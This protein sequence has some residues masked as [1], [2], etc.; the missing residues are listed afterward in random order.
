MDSTVDLRALQ[1]ASFGAE[2]VDAK[3]AALLSPNGRHAWHAA[4]AEHQLLVVRDLPLDAHEQVALAATLGEPLSRT[5]PDAPISSCRTATKKA[6]SATSD[7]PTTP[8]TRS[9]RSRST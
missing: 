7:S 3:L 8:T 6:S 1:G 2:I 4:L 5:R 9:W